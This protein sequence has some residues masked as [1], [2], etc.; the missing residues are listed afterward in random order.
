MLQLKNHAHQEKEEQH[1]MGFQ[2][3]NVY[4][5]CLLILITG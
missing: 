4:K 5:L 1:D 3:G 2:L